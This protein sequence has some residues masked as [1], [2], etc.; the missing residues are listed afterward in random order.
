MLKLTILTTTHYERTG[1]FDHD[2]YA[3]LN[4]EFLTNL[5]YSQAEKDFYMQPFQKL[6]PF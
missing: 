5:L 2:S 1:V 6:Y 4:I 3:L